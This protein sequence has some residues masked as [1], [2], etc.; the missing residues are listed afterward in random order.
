[1][2]LY[3][4]RV[5][6]SLIFRTMPF[7]LFRASVYFGI[8]AA[9]FVA[10]GV[11]AEI[12]R[13]MTVGAFQ[14]TAAT[15]GGAMGFIGVALIVMAFRKSLRYRVRA[16]HVALMAQAVDGN[17]I[18][19]G[20]GQIG[21]SH[22][23]VEDRFSNANTL[24]GIDRLSKGALRS[25]VTLLGDIVSYFPIPGIDRV[26]R[27]FCGFLKASVGTLDEAVLAH[28]VRAGAVNPWRSARDAV[29]LFGQRAQ[30][31]IASAALINLVSWAATMVVFLYMLAPAASL[32]EMLPADLASNG[33]VFA[34]VFTWAIKSGV[35]DPIANVFL[36][37]QF[38]SVTEGDRAVDAWVARLDQQSP[39]FH[40]LGVRAQGW[41]WKKT[42]R[43]WKVIRDQAARS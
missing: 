8:A 9:F 25:V 22:A 19:F 12:G 13:S 4:P 21:Y 37:W 33:I 14:P 36:L 29:V 24:Y 15:W 2:T 32:A 38:F 23:L 6:F 34:L 42:E 35:I 39:Q 41:V 17:E 31:L 11:G 26:A 43:R 10:T 20:L 27:P 16:R 30:P 3:G 28:V 18:P 40:A 1:M 5:V 7:F